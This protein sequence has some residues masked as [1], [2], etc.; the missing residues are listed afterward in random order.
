MAYPIIDEYTGRYLSVQGQLVLAE[1][2]SSASLFQPVGT[3]LYYEVV[4]VVRGIPLFWEDH[5]ARLIRSVQAAVP[6]PDS[7][8]AES[9]RLIRANGLSEANLRLVLADGMRV[10]HL[11]A[12]YYPTAAMMA[13]G[14]PTGILAWEREDPNIKIIRTDYKAAVA[15]GFARQG[16]F[17]RNFELLLADRQ[18][19]LTEGSRSNLFFIR[20]SQVLTAPDRLV[21]LG[22]T[23]QYVRRAV[24]MAGAD[25]AEGLLTLEDVRQGG[26]EAAFLSGSPIDLLPV[27]A[28][29]E[30]QLDSA[31]HPL[32]QRIITAYRRIVDRYV[33][34]RLTRLPDGQPPAGA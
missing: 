22:I 8:Y 4:R 12:S 24:E 21:L 17:G 20:N 23:R 28:I 1:D 5:L 31:G 32:L 15:A 19:R 9:L 10:I 11:T 16:P 13:Q 14:V 7:L 29:G 6:V 3:T 33:D 30:V 2:P 25:L 26:C 18:G 27:S 34:E